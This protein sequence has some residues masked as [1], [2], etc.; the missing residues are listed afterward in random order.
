MFLAAASIG[1]ASS[2][3]HALTQINGSEEGHALI[4]ELGLP[5]GNNIFASGAFGYN[6]SELPIAPPR[7]ENVV[8]ILK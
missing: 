8:T 6:A 1:I 5:E 4:K 2:W 7:K 3:I